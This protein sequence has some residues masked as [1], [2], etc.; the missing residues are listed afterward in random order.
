ML[1][2]AK[3][4]K[5]TQP[6]S[7][8]PKIPPLCLPRHMCPQNQFIDLPGALVLNQ[9]SDS[10]VPPLHNPVFARRRAAE[11]RS[12]FQRKGVL[13]L[14]P[15]LFVSIQQQNYKQT[16]P[17]APTEGTQASRPCSRCTC[18]Q[19]GD[20]IMN[21]AVKGKPFS[22]ES[23]T[24]VVAISVC[25]CLPALAAEYAAPTQHSRL[26]G[27]SILVISIVSAHSGSGQQEHG[28]EGREPGLAHHFATID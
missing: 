28:Q 15:L 27:V 17:R 3:K 14:Q 9:D 26:L 1:Q 4:V 6:T 7:I 12:L 23:L 19:S 18:A 25:S 22:A 21:K 11:V 2:N 24:W 13:S 16:S 8:S 20:C 10:D 5:Y